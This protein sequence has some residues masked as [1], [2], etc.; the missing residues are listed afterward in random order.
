[1]LLCKTRCPHRKPQSALFRA[2]AICTIS[3]LT[4]PLFAQDPAPAD[5]GSSPSNDAA[6]DSEP[7]SER[8]NLYYQATSIG[9]YHGTFHSPYEGARSLQNYPERDVSLT[10]TIFFGLRS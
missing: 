5:S 7:A 3:L 10:T 2:F 9:D 8:W 6:A 4:A 1:M